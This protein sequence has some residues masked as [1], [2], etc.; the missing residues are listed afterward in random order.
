MV[1]LQN[2]RS[3][4]IIQLLVVAADVPPLEGR[5]CPERGLFPISPSPPLGDQGPS[6]LEVLVGVK[7]RNCRLLLFA[8]F[9]FFP[10]YGIY[11][12][13]P[14]PNSW[15]S[16]FFFL[17]PIFLA[18]ASFSFG[19]SEK[20]G[21]ELRAFPDLFSTSSTRQLWWWWAFGVGF[22]ADGQ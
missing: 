22:P 20:P 19:D 4:W 21:R 10:K 7:E 8:Y 16:F 13:S 11:W 6:Q 9:F 1:S 14:C 5:V 3:F 2:G 18:K 12:T 17:S 15:I